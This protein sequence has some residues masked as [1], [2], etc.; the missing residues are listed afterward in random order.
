MKNELLE[1]NATPRAVAIIDRTTR[2]ARYAAPEVFRRQEPFWKEV[3]KRIVE[4]DPAI[5]DAFERL[6]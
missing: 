1:R 2:I 6:Y 3:R 5:R 4:K